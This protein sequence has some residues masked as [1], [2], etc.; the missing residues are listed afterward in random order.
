MSKT[1]K[2]APPA[3][4]ET[5][6]PELDEA[7]YDAPD[8]PPALSENEWAQWR[9]HRL[10]PVTMMVEATAFP[11]PPETLVKIIALAFGQLHD[12]DVRKII[13]REHVTLLRALASRIGDEP[14]P[15]A[16]NLLDPDDDSQVKAM[17]RAS[18]EMGQLDELADAI[19]SYL[20]PDWSIDRHPFRNDPPPTGFPADT[21]PS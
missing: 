10:N 17:K 11:T 6:E 2:Q 12:D 16:G 13:R 21:R 7:L 8:I 20:E 4:P 19:E 1:K 15:A 9:A 14:I 18:E 5:D 3:E